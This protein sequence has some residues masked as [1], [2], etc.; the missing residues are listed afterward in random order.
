M[1][2]PFYL[3]PRG[4]LP[5]NASTFEHEGAHAKYSPS[6]SDL[7][8]QHAPGALRSGASTKLLAEWECKQHEPGVLLQ[9]SNERSAFGCNTKPLAFVLALAGPEE[10]LCDSSTSKF[11]LSMFP[12]LHL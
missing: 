12:R 11:K 6:V 9:S 7:S 2:C 4:A 1:L 5:S 10:P 3:H 8:E